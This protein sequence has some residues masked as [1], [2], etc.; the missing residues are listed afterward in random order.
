MPMKHGTCMSAGE[1]A[2]PRGHC[3]SVAA[4]GLKK[5][6]AGPVVCARCPFHVITQQHLV[7]LTDELLRLKSITEGDACSVRAMALKAEA[8]TL[9]QLVEL[10]SRSIHAVRGS[11][12]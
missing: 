1:S 11:H 8:S 12:E 4:G 10:H 7:G 6:D 3:Y 2:Q 9:E 5:A